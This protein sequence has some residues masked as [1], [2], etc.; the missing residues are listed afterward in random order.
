MTEDNWRNAKLGHAGQCRS[1]E[2]MG[3]PTVFDNLISPHDI[4]DNIL[5]DAKAIIGNEPRAITV[6]GT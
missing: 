3:G 2:V 5:A 1:P 6:S 4:G